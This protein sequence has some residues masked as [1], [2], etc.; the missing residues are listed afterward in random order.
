MKHVTK[1]L[2]KDTSKDVYLIAY[3]TNHPDFSY[4]PDL[5]GGTMEEGEDSLEALLRELKEEA[6]FTLKADQPELIYEGD[7]YSRNGTKYYLY[8]IELD[9]R[10]PVTLSWEHSGYRWMPA[11]AF[12]P[13]AA[14]AI[15]TYMHMVSDV[16][17][18]R[19]KNK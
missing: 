3:R 13:E 1:L 7:A 6:D 5:F 17:A 10:L 8:Y 14:S 18:A 4:D 2:F 15:D 11:E 12:I 16:L 9:H 19:I